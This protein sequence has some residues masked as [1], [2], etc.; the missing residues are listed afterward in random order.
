MFL[1]LSIYSL[2]KPKKS[3]VSGVFR[4]LT[5]WYSRSDTKKFLKKCKTISKFSSK[6][7]HKVNPLSNFFNKVTIDGQ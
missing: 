2:K 5:L 3:I 6:V 4:L 1:K 7:S